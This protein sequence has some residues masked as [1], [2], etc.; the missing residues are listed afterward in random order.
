MKNM[1][2]GVMGGGTASPK[3]LDAAFRL[4]REIARNGWILLNGGRAAGI[5]E[6]SARGAFEEGG[7]TVGILP[8]E[9]DARASLYIRIPILTGMGN[10]RNSI[11]VLSSDL[12]VACS[13]GAGTLS[14]I[15]LGLK[16]GKN[17]ILMDFDVGQESGPFAPYFRQGLLHWAGTP[18]EVIQKIREIMGL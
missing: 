10:A 6:A 16:S 2:I 15:A 5:M 14:E 8:D 17:I 7:I 1:I 11:N 4:G 13:G 9:T 3:H 12:I 18:E